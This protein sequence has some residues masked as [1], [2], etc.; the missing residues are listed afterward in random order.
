MFNCRVRKSRRLLVVDRSADVM[1][2]FRA[3]SRP[4]LA[5]SLAFGAGAC[6]APSCAPAALA[7][8]PSRQAAA[9]ARLDAA[10]AA[11]AD[12]A[13]ALADAEAARDLY[14]DD[15]ELAWRAARAAWAA[16]RA[17]PAGARAGALAR[18]AAALARA[19][20]RGVTARCGAALRWEAI[21]VSEL[22]R[23]P[24]APLAAAADGAWRARDLLR[25]ALE[26]DAGD[27]AAAHLLG[28]WADAVAAVP[29]WKRAAVRLLAGAPLPA[30][31]REDACDAFARAE[32]AAPRAWPANAAEHARCLAERGGA[33]DR[34]EAAALARAVL[35]APPAPRDDDAR[36][37]SVARA[38]L[39]A[40]GE[41]E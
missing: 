30:A 22:S 18:A 7:A 20:G 15:G 27:A 3:L 25:Q 23:A 40:A 37:R 26:V 2:G 35:A 38:A 4:A 5:A 32:R 31:S 14:P 28:R 9:R 11:G 16:A 19:R 10:F 24:G 34:A 1:R 41:R 33:G 17:A 29:P 8:P 12:A 13:A 36:A 21:L 39:A 6:A